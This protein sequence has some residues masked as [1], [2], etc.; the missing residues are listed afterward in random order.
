M[1][2]AAQGGLYSGSPLLP[3]VCWGLGPNTQGH[4]LCGGVRLCLPWGPQT[5][6][7]LWACRGSSP[8]RP[9]RVRPW[10]QVPSSSTGGRPLP[11]QA[12]LGE[13][14][15][16]GQ[17]RRG[18]SW[19]ESHRCCHGS[20]ALALA[21]PPAHLCQAKARVAYGFWHQF[22]KQE[23]RLPVGGG[24]GVGGAVGSLRAG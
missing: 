5:R 1:C 9:C 12:A 10:V 24:G 21:Q 20:W 17:R 2:W 3:S 4:P 22:L 18:Q 19:F 13:P 6:P 23:G 15:L 8:L 11:S 14:G 16:G 7:S